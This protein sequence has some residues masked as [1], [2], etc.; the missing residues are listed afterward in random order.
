MGKVFDHIQKYN[1]NIYPFHMPGH[2]RIS[3]NIFKGYHPYEVDFTE[4]ETLDDLHCPEEMY[5]QSM[6]DMKEF[7]QTEETFYLVNGSTSGIM[8]SITA[9]CDLG[10]TIIVARNCHKSVY[11]AIELLG[12]NPVYIYPEIDKENGIVTHI[13]REKVRKIVD[14]HP[15]AK[16]VLLTS[17]TY[18]GNVMNISAIAS[19]TRQKGMALIVDEAHGAHFPF[20]DDFPES[21]IKEGA[22]LVIQSMHKTMPALTQTSL[23]HVCRTNFVSVKRVQ[24]CINYFETTSPSYLLTA[25][26]DDAFEFGKD[27]KEKF[28]YYYLKLK[29]VREKLNKLKHLSIVSVDDIG[30]IVIST[31][32]T[33][34]TG[35]ELYDILLNKYQLQME[36]AQE[37]YCIAMTSVCDSNEGY[38]RLIDA[39]FDIDKNIDNRKIERNHFS[40]EENKIIYRPYEA[41]RMMKESIKIKNSA[42][43]VSGEYVYLYPPGIPLIVP[44]EQI[45]E[46]CIQKIMDYKKYHFQ[47][48]GLEDSE[49]RMIKIVEN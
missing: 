1:K 26:I 43:F 45:N 2:K 17:P 4:I 8:A 21:A 39:L 14:N 16:A 49:C 41:K 34:M 18:E 9:I 22:D 36:M 38:D 20:G 40:M 13:S 31:A 5:R 46:K 32:K 19:I 15:N 10:D 3:R 35:K 27:E 11:M 25:S 24:E 23:L 28:H 7:Y 6:D 48:R 30:K 33:N 47:V 44:G 42:G 12:L 37:T 29:E